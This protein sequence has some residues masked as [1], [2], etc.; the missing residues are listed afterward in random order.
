MSGQSS[1]STLTEMEKQGGQLSDLEEMSS[2][3]DDD[4]SSMTSSFDDAALSPNSRAEHN[5]RQRARDE[6]RLILDLTKHQQLLIDSQKMSQSIKRCLGCTE[7]LIREG[8]RA[9]EYKVKVSE[10]KLGGRVL[11]GE[12]HD[13]DEQDDDDDHPV[14]EGLRERKGLL[15]PS[16]TLDMLEE[17]NLFSTGLH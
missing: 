16:A 13:G 12:D 7:E 9:L 8:T 15:S 11:H 5:S 17:A 6:R 2:D 4:S 10:V 3:D 14:E 1:L